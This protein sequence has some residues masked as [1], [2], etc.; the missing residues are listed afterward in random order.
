MPRTR[1]F[2]LTDDTGNRTFLKSAGEGAFAGLRMVTSGR[3]HA[4]TGPEPGHWPWQDSSQI[5]ASRLARYHRVLSEAV[6]LL[7]RVIPASF[8]SVFDG[9]EAIPRALQLHRDELSGLLARYGRLRQFSLVLK[10]DELAMQR[11][12]R[13]LGGNDPAILERE[14]RALR[15]QSLLLLQ[16]HLRDLIILNDDTRETV[17]RAVF[18]VQSAQENRLVGLLQ[19]LDKEC[20]GRLHIRLVGPLPACNFARVEIKLPDRMRVRQARQDLG[21]RSAARVADMKSA[22]RRKVKALH[23]DQSASPD[24][25]EL[26]VRLTRS[27]RYLS[28]LAVQQNDRGTIN[29]EKQ[30]LRCDGKTLRQ[31]PLLRIQRGMTRWDDIVMKTGNA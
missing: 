17:L 5:T 19:K 30:W 31:T 15:D 18:L 6:R 25:H 9:A 26:M 2:A 1:I 16:G 23:P 12:M 28:Q 10:W 20:H 22:Y 3:L 21:L 24:N 7:D 11:V 8:D 27:Y 13:R 4:L 14:R 29:S